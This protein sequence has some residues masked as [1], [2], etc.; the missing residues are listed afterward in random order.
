MPQIKLVVT[1]EE[2][3]QIKK[4]ARAAGK[5]LSAYVRESALN[6]FVF[7]CDSSDIVNDHI[8]EISSLRNSINQLIYTIE[9]TGDYYPS[10]LEAIHD[11]MVEVLSSEKNFLTLMEKDILKKRKILKTQIERVTNERL[12]LLD[13]TKRKTNKYNEEV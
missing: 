7:E 9:K 8:K 13:K 11:L 12:K 4:N 5:T 3:L 1:E 6:F 2:Q 10:E